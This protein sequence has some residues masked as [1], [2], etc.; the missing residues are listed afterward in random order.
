MHYYFQFISNVQS[1]PNPD[2][3]NLKNQT[4][5]PF[6]PQSMIF[7]NSQNFVKYMLYLHSPSKSE[8]ST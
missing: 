1:A 4:L 6:H 8:Y 7:H 2:I 3:N 5:L